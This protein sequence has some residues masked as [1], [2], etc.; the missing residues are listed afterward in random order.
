M[1][2]PTIGTNYK[3]LSGFMCPLLVVTFHSSGSVNTWA[4]SGIST[5][6]ECRVSA[7]IS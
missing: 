6:P 7:V 1:I 3:S 5:N 4:W 2:L